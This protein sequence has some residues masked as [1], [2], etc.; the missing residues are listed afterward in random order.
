MN[1]SDMLNK[2][3]LMDLDNGTV[4]NGYVYIRDYTIMP[5]KSGGSYIG[6]HIEC[7]GTMPFKVW[8]SPTFNEMQA[9]DYTNSICK[10]N[11]EINDYAGTRSLILKIVSKY[12]G[13]D[14]NIESFFEHKYNINEMWTGLRSILEKNC[15]PEAVQVFDLLI[16]GETK[17]RFVK[18][19][20]AIYHHDNCYN[21]LLAH[22]WKVVRLTQIV[23]FY[24]TIQNVLDKD[25]LFVGAA[26]HDIGKIL[27]Y[28][29][30]TITPEGRMMSHLTLGVFLIIPLKDRII[31]LKGK[32]FYDDLISIVQQHH[33]EFGE[34]SRTL[35]AYIIHKVDMLD[36]QLTSIQ[37]SIE[38]A[39][40]DEIKVDDLKLTFDKAE[41]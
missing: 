7:L 20:A 37:E 1:T 10:I 27:E 32:K 18:E 34:R 14:V 5:M 31:E 41:E 6:G 25:A 22:S 29:N 11:A 36:A 40:S 3:S 28:H 4:V 16:S 26:I 33:N 30:G 35:I 21:G 13:D 9:N 23:K 8:P 17:E 19:F 24:P 38:N 15:T 12:D 39:T 2:K